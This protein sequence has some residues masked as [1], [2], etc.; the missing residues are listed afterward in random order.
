MILTTIARARLGVEAFSAPSWPG[1]RRGDPSRSPPRRRWRSRALARLLH[2]RLL[3]HDRARARLLHGFNLGF[4]VFFL[5][6]ACVIKALSVYLGAR[7]AGENNRSSW[8]LAVAMNARGG[9]GIIVASTAFAAGSSTSL[10]C[11]L[12]LLGRGQLARA[13]SW[14][15]RAPGTP[16]RSFG[17][18]GR[19]GAGVREL[20]GRAP[21]R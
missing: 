7:V 8:N 4:F 11:L 10:S 21:L 14:L 12:I 9:P 3:R 18:C 6:A 16:A 20:A 2:S 17:A 15:E 19:S 1:C 5:L 13:G